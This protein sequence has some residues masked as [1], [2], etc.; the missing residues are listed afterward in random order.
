MVPDLDAALRAHEKQKAAQPHP[1][2]RPPPRPP[3]MTGVAPPRKKAAVDPFM[4]PRKK[5]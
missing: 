2:A 4:K 1:G 5:R 3:G